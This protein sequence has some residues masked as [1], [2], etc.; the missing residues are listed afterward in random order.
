MP[1]SERDEREKEKTR[2]NVKEGRKIESNFEVDRDRDRLSKGVECARARARR[3]QRYASR[4]IRRGPNEPRGV[5][6]QLWR[7]KRK[8][9]KRN[10]DGR[11]ERRTLRYVN[12]RK[13]ER[14]E[15]AGGDREGRTGRM[16]TEERERTKGVKK[17]E[18]HGKERRNE[19]SSGN[20]RKRTH[21]GAN[22]RTRERERKRK[23]ARGGVFGRGSETAA[24]VF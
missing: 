8:S 3:M 24:Y 11:R 2:W 23:K 6:Y 13:G 17:R 21:E 14:D 10:S 5:R 12:E 15:G 16:Q 19:I 1:A 18:V 9:R 22:G 4:A 20:A 7:G